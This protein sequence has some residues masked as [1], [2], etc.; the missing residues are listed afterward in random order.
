MEAGRDRHP[1]PDEH[2]Q[3][4]AGWDRHPVLLRMS[5][6]D[7]QEGIPIPSCPAAQA[8]NSKAGR[9][10]SPILESIG[11]GETFAPGALR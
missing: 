3:M 1:L 2:E 5:K 9:D 6:M 4:D 8:S 11:R 7:S 10:S